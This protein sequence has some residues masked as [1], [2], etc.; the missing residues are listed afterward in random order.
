MDAIEKQIMSVWYKSLKDLPDMNE[1][2]GS[3][4]GFRGDQRV[5]ALIIVGHMM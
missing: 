4:W 1:L 5:V 2:S 3:P